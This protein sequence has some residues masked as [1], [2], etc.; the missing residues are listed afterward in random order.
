[1]SKLIPL[2]LLASSSFAG[3]HVSQALP[4][5]QGQQ[6][7]PPDVFLYEQVGGTDLKLYVFEPPN[8]D[9]RKPRGAIVLFHG[10]GWSSGSAA[11]IFAIARYFA[12]LG[13]VGIS[14]EYRLADGKDITPFE[15]VEDAKASLRWVRGHAAVLNV[16][17]KKIAAYGESAGAHLAAATAIVGENP[18][19]EDLSGV[20]NAM[21]LFSPALDI[22]QNERFKKLIGA[23]RDVTSISPLRHI[24]KSMPPTIILTGALDELIPSTTLIDY[25]N[26]MK[27][28]RNRC[29]LEIYP[30]VGHML[31]PPGEQGTGNANSSKT[32]YDAFLRLDQFLLSLGFLPPAPRK[33]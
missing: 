12:S 29:D 8:S 31:E 20:P 7:A 27:Q 33:N 3:G 13:M 28:A 9:Y 6:D 5:P 18:A 26:R 19:G 30:G 1:M 14:V 15:A 23:G 17:P 25:C 10:G 24:R 32:K 2:L 16:D 21:V 4:E 11:G 22:E